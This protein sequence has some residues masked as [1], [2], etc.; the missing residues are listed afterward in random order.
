MRR[1]VLLTVLA[2]GTTAAQADS[3]L[4]YVGAGVTDSSLTWTGFPEQP[5]DL[6]NNSWKAFAGVRPLKWLAVGAD[7]IDLGNGNSGSQLNDTFT[8]T[9]HADSSAW[10]AYAVGFL[11]VP[12]PVV[13]FYGKVG[14]AR[15]QLNISDI[16]VS[17]FPPPGTSIYSTSH[18]GLTL[19]G[20]SACRR[21][22]RCSACAWNTR[23][24]R[25]TVTPRMSGH[26]RFS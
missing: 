1:P 17:N 20:A 14:V 9:V 19:P 22:S 12:L 15:W 11:P 3:G 26:C 13:D 23:A 25:L 6:K 24:S 21:T 8:G 2:L 5:V 10:C 16:Q 7:Y 18:S 4:F